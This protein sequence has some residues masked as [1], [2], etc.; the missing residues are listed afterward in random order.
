MRGAAEGQSGG[1]VQT[2]VEEAAAESAEGCQTRLVFYLTLRFVFLTELSTH[3]H[4]KILTMIGMLSNRLHL[5]LLLSAC[6][7]FGQSTT[8]SLL[9][10]VHD[11]SGAAVPGVSVT[12]TNTQT[13][14][15]VET[16]SASD[17]Q[18]VITPL[19]PGPYR[20]EA[21]ATGFKRF[22]R[23]GIVLQVLQQA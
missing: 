6:A 4:W 16:K 13:N 22:L 20:I 21:G 2:H 23:D 18:Y 3:R 19:P 14:Q 10:S 7:A 15:Q 9:G 11:T 5:L 12:A 1:Y 8:G 17:G